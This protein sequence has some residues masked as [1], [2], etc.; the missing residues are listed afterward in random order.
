MPAAWGGTDRSRR[1]RGFEAALR[2]WKSSGHVI[3][4]LEPAGNPGYS[5]LDTH[6]ACQV[7]EIDRRC[8]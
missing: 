4:A 8:S 5:G 6:M 3:R 7:I 1:V 2:R